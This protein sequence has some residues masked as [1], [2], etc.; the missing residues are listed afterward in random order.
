LIFNKLHAP[1]KKP[2]SR[3]HEDDVQNNA[4]MCYIVTLLLKNIAKCL[5]E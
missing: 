5:Y 3:L 2:V 1:S 4:M